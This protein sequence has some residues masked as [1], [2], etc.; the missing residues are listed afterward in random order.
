MSWWLTSL[1]L[2]ARAVASVTA[3]D[4]D[5]SI[6]DIQKALSGVL[7]VSIQLAGV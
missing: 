2:S 7:A 1:F 3:G 5:Y 4:F 6:M